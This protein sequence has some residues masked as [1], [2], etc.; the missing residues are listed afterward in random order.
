MK[1]DLA[2]I[3]AADIPAVSRFMHD[4]H[5][6]RIAPEDWARALNVPWSVS[7][8]NHGFV[9]RSGGEI[10]GAYLAYYADR[11]VGGRVEQFCN[12]GAWCV[13]ESYRAEGVRLLM[14]L[15]RMRGYHFTDFSPSGSVVPLNRKLKFTELDTSTSLLLNVPWPVSSKAI[16]VVEDPDLLSSTLTGPERQIYLDHRDA[17]AARHLL[18]VA[19]ERHCHVIFRKDTRKRIRAFASIL[20][21]TDAELFQSAVRQVGSHLL[22]KHGA[23]ATLMEQRVVGGRPRGTIPLTS[24]RPK[25]FKSTSL[26][27]DEVDYLYSELV[28]LEW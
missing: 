24:A 3:A 6:R 2:P 17:G 21:V 27:A 28:C 5:N 16:R 19:G 10:V 23:A 25:M 18:L 1:A 8:P 15:L 11:E 14:A 13:L 7:V 20:Y 26:I 4:H 12:L 9:L 22:L